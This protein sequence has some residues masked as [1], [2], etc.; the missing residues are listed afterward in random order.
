MLRSSRDYFQ[1]KIN[2]DRFTGSGFQEYD[3]SIKEARPG[4][5]FIHVVDIYAPKEKIEHGKIV[6]KLLNNVLNKQNS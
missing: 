5:R 6:F 1:T 3:A 2:Q 4:K